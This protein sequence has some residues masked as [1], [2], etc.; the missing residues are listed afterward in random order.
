M[1]AKTKRC[2]PS[3][4]H[5]ILTIARKRPCAVKGS[6]SDPYLIPVRIWVQSRGGRLWLFGG[7]RGGGGRGNCILINVGRGVD[8]TRGNGFKKS[9]L[10]MYQEWRAKNLKLSPQ[11]QFPLRKKKWKKA[12]YLE[13]D[14]DLPDSEDH[15][16]AKNQAQYYERKSCGLVAP[17]IQ[18]GKRQITGN[19]NAK[20]GGGKKG[21]G[22]LVYSTQTLCIQSI[23]AI[24]VIAGFTRG[25]S[26][27]LLL[28]PSQIWPFRSSSAATVSVR[29]VYSTHGLLDG[30]W[31][32]RRANRPEHLCPVYSLSCF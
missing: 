3:T 6:S 13:V 19:R 2:Q 15:W 22:H 16:L 11:P 12:Y 27:E 10:K 28:P 4:Q 14:E 24:Y 26:D 18:K 25:S 29:P 20:L 32:G 9:W 1:S 31:I 5:E 8:N 23:D 30:K 17:Q 7:G 21:K